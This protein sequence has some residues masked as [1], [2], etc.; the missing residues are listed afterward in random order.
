MSRTT[1]NKR[2]RLSRVENAAKDGDTTADAESDSD[3]QRIA[4]LTRAAV[5]DAQIASL[6]DETDEEEGDADDDFDPSGDHAAPRPGRKEATSKRLRATSSEA[7]EQVL[8]LSNERFQIPEI[9]FNPSMIGAH[10]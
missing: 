7:E 1:S 10:T 3:D 9:I 8:M 4:D 5:T 2:R 6:D